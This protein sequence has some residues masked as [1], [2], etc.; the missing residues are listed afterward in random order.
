MAFRG[1]PNAG[2][3]DPQFLNFLFSRQNQKAKEERQLA[4]D[5]LKAGQDYEEEKRKRSEFEM[6]KAIKLAEFEA[7]HGVALSA[8]QE[9][10]QTAESNIAGAF[11][12]NRAANQATEAQGGFNLPTGVEGPQL[13][14]DIASNADETGP[15]GTAFQNQQMAP[16]I[17]QAE[18]ISRAQQF[19]LG[20]GAQSPDELFAQAENIGQTEE[21]I[22]KR[23]RNIERDADIEKEERQIRQIVSKSI[24]TINGDVKKG[25]V[26]LSHEASLRDNIRLGKIQGLDTSIDEER[27]QFA[28]ALRVG[29]TKKGQINITNPPSP[30]LV[31]QVQLGYGTADEAVHRL[32]EIQ[33]QWQDRIINFGV[34]GSLQFGLEFTQEWLGD[35]ASA[36][37]FEGA[38]AE[39]MSALVEQAQTQ[40]GPLT[41]E[42]SNGEILTLDLDSMM[43]AWQYVRSN[44]DTARITLLEFTTALKQLGLTGIFKTE[45]GV[46]SALRKVTGMTLRSRQRDRTFLEADFSK[47]SLTDVLDFK[48]NDDDKALIDGWN[49]DNRSDAP[50]A[51]SGA[52]GGT[53]GG[54]DA[55]NFDNL[56]E[57]PTDE[58]LRNAM[59]N[60]AKARLK[61]GGN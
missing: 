38:G 28:K 42:D 49:R 51:R 5:R 23:D 15:I 59:R 50:D 57:S 33:K 61:A 27:L 41:I 54:P 36:A 3:A 29:I 48:L 58:Q 35:L 10:R 8:L 11:G 53:V 32:T 60:A 46:L 25:D 21:R 34:K 9:S 47:G 40:S 13:T 26:L 45:A 55:T 19:A 7:K 22:A 16:V 14:A 43:L 44:K 1:N 31:R 2:A 39:K 4:L 18:R 6:N 12:A 52:E 56:P 24:A 37:I 17:G 30:T 20:Q